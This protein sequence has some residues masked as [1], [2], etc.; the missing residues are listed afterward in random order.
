[1]Q[2]DVKWNRA[3]RLPCSAGFEPLA[4]CYQAYIFTGLRLSSAA[5]IEVE[6]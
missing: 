5:E 1:M 6:S 2:C 3:G 4:M